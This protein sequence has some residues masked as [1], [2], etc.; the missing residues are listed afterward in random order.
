MIKFHQRQLL[1]FILDASSSLEQWSGFNRAGLAGSFS[2]RTLCH[3]VPLL[4]VSCC[5]ETIA[6]IYNTFDTGDGVVTL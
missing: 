1:L 6:N 2:S 4:F 3:G 5:V